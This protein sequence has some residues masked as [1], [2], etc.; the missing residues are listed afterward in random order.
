MICARSGDAPR[1][2]SYSTTVP[3]PV[4]PVRELLGS[5]H[6]R[7]LERVQV[8]VTEARHARRQD[9]VG[10]LARQV[11]ALRKQRAPVDRLVDGLPQRHVVLEDAAR[12]VER[13]VR[14]REQRLHPELALVDAVL[15]GGLGVRRRRD[16]A[17]CVVGRT[18]LDAEIRR[19]E[20][21]ADR[22]GDLRRVVRA[23]ALVVRVLLEQDRPVRD[24]VRDVV[25]PGRRRRVD[26]V[27]VVRPCS[28]G[29]RRRTA[30]RAA[31]AG[32]ARSASC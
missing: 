23:L 30:S 25:R 29:V 19:V 22:V 18:L 17:G 2:D 10:P 7:L 1:F 14:R 12:R 5:A 31:R 21:V 20:R 28:P 3:S 24:P 8:G 32:P 27:R 9:L 11:A 16:A 4:W 15:L 6:V 26:A 13:E